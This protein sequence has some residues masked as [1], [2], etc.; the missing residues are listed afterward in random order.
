MDFAIPPPQGG[1]WEKI[2]GEF[3]F[4]VSKGDFF[5]SVFQI[6]LIFPQ[7]ALFRCLENWTPNCF[8][9]SGSPLRRPGKRFAFW[10]LK[11]PIS[12]K[13]ASTPQIE[14]KDLRLVV[15]IID[16]FIIVYYNAKIL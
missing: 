4:W 11:P 15:D 13:E 9:G 14:S 6:F 16:S 8:R 12:L 10:W 1:F 3:F 2:V 5:Q 7:K